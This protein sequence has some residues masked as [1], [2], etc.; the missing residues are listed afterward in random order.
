MYEFDR[1]GCI[2]FAIAVAFGS[3]IFEI[4][5]QGAASVV[6]RQE[7]NWIGLVADNRQ[8]Q[9]FYNKYSLKTDQLQ[10]Q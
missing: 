6:K 1:M 4:R 5:Q 9:Q 8:S 2:A 3:L 7:Q 10:A